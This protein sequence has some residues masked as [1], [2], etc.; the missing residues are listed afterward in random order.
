MSSA[1]YLWDNQRMVDQLG[2]I[3]GLGV[4]EVAPPLPRLRSYQHYLE[5][6]HWLAEEVMPAVAGDGTQDHRMLGARDR[7]ICRVLCPT[8]QEFRRG[9]DD[10]PGEHDVRP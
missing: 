3:A 4:T 6:L 5:R 7:R 8:P 2:W 1:T 9:A 10:L